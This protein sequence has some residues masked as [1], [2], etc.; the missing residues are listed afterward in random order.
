MSSFTPHLIRHSVRLFRGIRRPGL[1][2]AQVMMRNGVS[3]FCRA[4]PLFRG[5]RRPGLI[6]AKP[7]RATFIASL[8]PRA[9]PGHS[10]PR[11]H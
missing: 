11:P 9:L 10:T 5:I 1:I 4:P 3:C 2:E 6:E 8:M 7:I